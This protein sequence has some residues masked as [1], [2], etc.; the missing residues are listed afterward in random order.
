MIIVIH[1]ELGGP[2]LVLA[3]VSNEMAGDILSEIGTF[4][5]VQIV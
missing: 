2:E 1:G 5:G 4:M 3:E